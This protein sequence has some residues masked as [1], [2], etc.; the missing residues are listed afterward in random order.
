M[1]PDAAVERRRF[2]SKYVT[3]AK[4][5]SVVQLRLLIQRGVYDAFAEKLAKRVADH[6]KL[7]D[8]FSE[9]RFH[10]PLIK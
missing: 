6:S 5:Q 3:L 10:G 2:A 9:R 8:G 7:A 4:L 1:R